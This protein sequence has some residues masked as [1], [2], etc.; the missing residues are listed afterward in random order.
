MNHFLVLRAFLFAITLLPLLSC[1]QD[2]N[3][4]ATYNHNALGSRHNL[5]EKYPTLEDVKNLKTKWTFPPRDS[6]EKGRRMRA[7]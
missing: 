6:Q 1:A 3:D 7:G 2:A 4:C 5:A